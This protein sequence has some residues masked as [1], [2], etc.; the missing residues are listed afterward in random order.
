M[1]GYK[2]FFKAS[3]EKDFSDIPKKDLQRILNRIKGLGENPR[4]P[5]CEKLTGKEGRYRLRQG[6]YRIVYSVQDKDLTVQ[7]V[8]VAHRKNVYR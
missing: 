3:V 7:V 1:G 2:V 4:P 6:K 8:K 5:G